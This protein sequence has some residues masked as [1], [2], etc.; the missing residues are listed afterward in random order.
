M[1][2]PAE[3]RNKRKR[4]VREGKEGG[5]RCKTPK[6]GEVWGGWAATSFR[7]HK[8]EKF[9][10]GGEKWP[11]L[12]REKK[13]ENRRQKIKK[14]KAGY[15]IDPIHKGKG[16]KRRT[17]KTMIKKKRTMGDDGAEGNPR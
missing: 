9:C 3:N 11:V 16:A 17:V 14:K 1:G 2:Y 15:K 13:K 7:G 8:G 10:K 6:R 5:K 4:K 12:G